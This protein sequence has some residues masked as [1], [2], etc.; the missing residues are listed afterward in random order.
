MPV[1]AQANGFIFCEG[2]ETS[3][4]YRILD[5]LLSSSGPHI[6]PIGGKYSLNAFIEGFCSAY[7]SPLQYIAFRDRDFDIKPP[8]SPKLLAIRG[9]KPVWTT[10]RA[11]IESYLI[12][13]RLF[14][15]FWQSGSKGPEWKLGESPDQLVFQQIILES[16]REISAYQAVRWALADLKPGDRWPEIRTTWL[17]GSG[18]LPLSFAYS[19]CI[20]KARELVENY[21]NDTS[22]ISIRKLEEKAIEYQEC[23][24][25]EEFYL[26]G[27]HLIW[28]H[29][30]DLLKAVCRKLSL[31]FPFPCSS[32]TSW[33]V[34]QLDLTAYPDF[35]DLKQQCDQ[36]Q[37]A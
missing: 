7:N 35:S 10:Y 6:V 31:Q 11:C 19:D 14:Y 3:Y 2:K 20:A 12:D 5:R 29:G 33:A 27:Q 28:F 36:F 25:K 16:A 8:D 15:E 26:L 18:E 32:Y 1:T 24:S 23:F 30:K 22:Q 4:D 13:S 21:L 17:K 9:Q 37:G 34:E